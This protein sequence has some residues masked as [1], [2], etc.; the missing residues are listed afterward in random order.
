VINFRYHVVSIVA[1]FLALSIGIV[2]GSTQLRGRTIDLLEGAS[3]SA[4]NQVKA[5]HAINAALNRQVS[6]DG[7]FATA[8]AQRIIGGLLANQRVVLVSAPN[9]PG[10]VVSGV[11]SALELA[12]AKVTGQVSLQPLVFD[13]SASNQSYIS[14]IVATLSST[15]V[16]PPNGSP[17]EQ[18]SWLLGSAILTKSDPSSDTQSGKT[19]GTTDTTSA[20]GE[21]VLSS[22]AQAGLLSVTS[23][24]PGTDPATLAVVVTPSTVPSDGNSDSTNQGLVTLAQELDTAGLGTVMVGSTSGSVAGSAIDTLRG[25]NAAAQISTVDDADTEI[26]QIISVQALALALTGHKPGNYGVDPGN[27]AAAPSPAPTPAASTSSTT[28]SQSQGSTRK[29]SSNSKSSGKKT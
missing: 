23:G 27:S 7:D 4:Q 19:S 12:G 14:T 9:A 22:Y 2:L 17:L 13:P 26:G 25:S 10:S 11:T 28:T 18:A 29:N 8:N 15:H 3:A 20:S 5:Q 16:Q 1:V 21:S 6:G 24:Q